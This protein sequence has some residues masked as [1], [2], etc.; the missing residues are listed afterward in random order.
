M[1]S[2]LLEILLILL[3]LTVAIANIIGYLDQSISSLILSILS[4]LFSM[5]YGA[6]RHKEIQ[7]RLRLLKRKRQKE[8]GVSR[9]KR[10]PAMAGSTINLM[11]SG[12]MAG[13]SG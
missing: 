3:S 7:G 1:R 11:V 12:R 8:N 13:A 2:Q 10:R 4:I 5:I 9:I 6:R